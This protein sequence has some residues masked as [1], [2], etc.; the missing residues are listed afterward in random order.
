VCLILFAWRADAHYPLV[1]AANRDEFYARPTAP[2]SYWEDAPQVLAGRDLEA[3]GTWMGIARNG[4]FA[5]ITNFRDP[6]RVRSGAPSR[7]PLVSGFLHGSS[8]PRDYLERLARQGGQYNGFNLLVGDVE[9]LWYYSN[10]NGVP[11]PVAPGIHGLSNH[12]LDTPW[13]KVESGRRELGLMLHHHPGP[14]AHALLAM[15]EDRTLAPDDELPE[16]GVGLAR[17]RALSPKFIELPEYGTR[18][19]TALLASGDGDVSVTEKTHA[20]SDLREFH[21]SWPAVP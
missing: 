21:L 12:L 7:G 20:T 13:P 14:T 18:C 4:R 1:V 11:R 17:E 2:M 16:T 5:A 6:G 15:L 19:S 9:A 8:T 3:G 10:E